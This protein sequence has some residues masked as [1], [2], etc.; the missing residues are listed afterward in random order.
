M[1]STV[2]TINKEITV[3]KNKNKNNKWK[4]SFQKGFKK[5]SFFFL[6]FNPSKKKKTEENK[7][8]KEE[9]LEPL[10]LEY[11]SKRDLRV[12]NRLNPLL[13]SNQLKVYADQI[14]QYS[15]DSMK[16]LFLVQLLNGERLNVEK[17]KTEQN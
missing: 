14:N 8:R 9:G 7:Q 6:F 16:K 3:T 2:I 12:P 1:K 15:N 17:G 13:F 11:E 10:S 5:K 4:N